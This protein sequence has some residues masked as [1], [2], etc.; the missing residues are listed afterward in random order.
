MTTFDA[1]I[2]QGVTEICQCWDFK[3]ADGARIGFTDH[4]RD[5][6]FDEVLYEAGSALSA[7]SLERK[8]GLGTANF[9]IEGR[10]DDKIF[11]LDDLLLGRFDGAEIRV[12]QVVWSNISLR[13]LAFFG[14]IGEVE[15]SDETRFRAEVRGISDALRKPVGRRYLRSCSAR[16]G[17]QSC[18]VRLNQ[19]QNTANVQVT[20]LVTDQIIEVTGAE[21][22]AQGALRLGH[23]RAFDWSRAASIIE[24]TVYEGKR[25]ITHDGAFHKTLSEGQSLILTVGCDKSIETCRDKFNNLINFQGFP[26]LPSPDEI[27]LTPKPGGGN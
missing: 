18:G 10:L 24:D 14:E 11:T 19:A 26:F 16:L 8:L 23:A 7:S 6:A 9:E 4:D 25:R 3:T 12:W 17:D 27:L 13:K 15:I 1:Y 21:H 22:I 5:L 20:K 2:A